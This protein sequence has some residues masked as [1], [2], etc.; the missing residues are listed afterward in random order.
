MGDMR[1]GPPSTGETSLAL[2]GDYSLEVVPRPQAA[3]LTLRSAREGVLLSFEVAITPAGAV[4]RGRAAALEID[5]SRVATRCDEF[6][7]DAR[8]RI[9]LRSGQSLTQTA[10][11]AMRLAGGDLAVDANVGSP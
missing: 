6:L 11:G 7:V 1:D 2:G 10:E 4:V 3:M 8:E 9:E 5:A